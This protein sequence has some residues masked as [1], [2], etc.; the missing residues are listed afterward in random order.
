MQIAGDGDPAVCSLLGSPLAPQ[1]CSCLCLCWPRCVIA[2]RARRVSRRRSRLALAS[3]CLAFH[4]LSVPLLP[5]GPRRGKTDASRSTLEP[6]A[7]ALTAALLP[8]HRTTAAR[9][10]L[11]FL[12]WR[13]YIAFARQV[14][15][16]LGP[17]VA[18]WFCLLSA[19][20]FHLP[21]YMSRTLPN[22]FVLP[23]GARRCTP[24]LALDVQRATVLFFSKRPFPSSSACFQ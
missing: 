14:S 4:A 10:A 6:A 24:A 21:F 5:S 16:L 17:L 3:L 20:Q 12:S 9:L 18:A 7:L 8:L 2:S 23:L 15:G 11:G 1:R 22:S 19:V 13:C